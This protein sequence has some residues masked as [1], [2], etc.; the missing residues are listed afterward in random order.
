MKDYF[1]FYNK[2]GK[3]AYIKI[4]KNF[5]NFKNP[6]I[7]FKR[8]QDDDWLYHLPNKKFKNCLEA[9]EFIMKNLETNNTKFKIV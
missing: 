7:K 4:S 1:K 9:V 2:E 3:K 5:K 6:I 8:P